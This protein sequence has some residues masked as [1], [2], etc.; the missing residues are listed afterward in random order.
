MGFGIG[1]S[2]SGMGPRN[3]MESFAEGDGKRGQVFNQRV[4][5]RMLV[6]LRPYTKMMTLAFVA[7]LADST[8]TLLIPYLLK[9]TVDT[10]ISQ[11]DQAG[12]IRISLLTAGTFLGLYVANR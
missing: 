2:G 4:V 5:T 1:V 8:L 11:G 12:L 9:I 3:A 10:Y 7:M 6:Y